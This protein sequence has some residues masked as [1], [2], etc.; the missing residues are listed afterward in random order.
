[1]VAPAGTVASVKVGATAIPSFEGAG[2]EPAVFKTQSE[3]FGKQLG[4]ALKAAGY[5]SK[6]DP[7]QTNEWL[8]PPSDCDF[9]S[10]RAA[11]D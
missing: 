2:L 4:D 8:G 5:P 1:M 11:S 6:A 10:E 3:A 9:A 7:A